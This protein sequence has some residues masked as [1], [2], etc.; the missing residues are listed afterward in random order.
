MIL[1]VLK[2]PGMETRVSL[3]PE[4]VKQLVGSGNQ[5][6]VEKEAGMQA[7]LANQLYEDAGAKI[8]ERDAL[9]TSA[10]M[11]FQIQPLGTE[12]RAKLGKGKILIGV[13]QPLVA[14][15]LMQEIAQQGITLL[16]M[17]AI[18]RITRAQSMDVLSSM[19]TVSG[20]KAVL[21]A[22]SQLPRFF[23]MLMTAAGTVAPAKVL[24]IG[25]GVA[26]LQA[27]ATAKRL[28]AVVEAFDTRPSV[29]EQ[30]ESLGGKFVEVPG[31]VED[32]AAGGYAVEQS[33]EYK[34]KQSEMLEKS[35]VKSDVII[36]TALIPGRKA[37]IL[38]TREML[39]KMKPGAVIV[40]LAS[41]NGGNCEGTVDNQTV[42]VEGVTIIGNSA[43]PATMPEDA[44]KMYSKNVHNL[45][46]LLLKE[47]QLNLNFGDEI[48][49]G[50]CITHEGAIVYA[51]LI[52]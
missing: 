19:S 14:K 26:G 37:P 9:L 11:I 50:T 33:E 24:V 25:A 47:D 10:E 42:T 7:F 38:V 32:K 13:Y 31:A 22:A 48:I 18:P 16:S 36:T 15:E 8:V 49:K 35:I 44:T 39:V 40:D 41:I 27:I 1:G 30:V 12:E 3:H 43:L 20:Y 4:A 45:L 5:V 28:G 6:L 51:P 23:P 29:K 46:K 34:Q 17:D 2:E 21:L 52:N